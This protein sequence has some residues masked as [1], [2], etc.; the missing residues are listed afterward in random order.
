LN[1]PE[2]LSPV[3]NSVPAS[4]SKGAKLKMQNPQK[5]CRP[6]CAA[7]CATCY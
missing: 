6:F 7:F 4:P 1:S 5:V 3:T 2:P